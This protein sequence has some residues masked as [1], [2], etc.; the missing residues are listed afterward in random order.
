[1]TFGCEQPTPH[2]FHIV[3]LRIRN[4]YFMRRQIV[5]GKTM[6]RGSIVA[7]L[8]MWGGSLIPFVSVATQVHGQTLTVMSSFNGT[9]L[10]NSWGGL[11]LSGS[12]LYG[13]TINGGPNN[14]GT[15]FSLPLTGGTSTVLASF[16]GANGQGPC[17]TLT[18][19]GST[20]YGTTPKGGANNDGTVFS[21]PVTGG[22][23]T[24]LTSFNNTNG[25]S[26]AG[27]LA[28]SGSTLYGTTSSG[29]GYGEGEVFSLPVT[30]GNP[31][32]LVSCNGATSNPS[33]GVLLSGNTLYGTAQTGAGDFGTVFSLPAGGGNP[34][35][36][37][38]F[39]G[40]NGQWPES[41]LV[42]SGTTLYG[43]AFEGGASWNGGIGG[44]G[45]VFSV[46]VTGGTPTVLA[47]FNGVNG[48]GPASLAISGRILYGTTDYGGAYG[49]GEAFSIP[50]TGGTLTVLHSFNFTDGAYPQNGVT[51]VGSTLYG[52]TNGGGAFNAGEVFSL[53]LPNFAQYSWNADASG[54]WSVAS[55]WD[56]ATRYGVNDQVTFGG[57]ITAPRTITVDSAV[58]A[59]GLTFNSTPAY[60]IAGSRSI[61]LQA[62][63]GDAILNVV[64]G[65]HAISAPL[66][67]ASN[68]DVTFINP[69]N[70]L[71]ISGSISGSETAL[72]L[73]GAGTLVLGAANT[74]SG[75]TDVS[76]GTLQL[77]HPL[78]VQNSTV[79]VSAS[80]ALAFAAGVTNPTLGGLA[81]AGNISLA[82]AASQPVTLGAGGNG[83]NTV[84][85][86]A[87]SGAG[88]L[89]KQ[90]GGTLTLAGTSTYAGPTLIAGGIL[91]LQPPANRSIGVQFY[92]SGGAAALTGTGGV[93]PMTNWNC[94]P[95]YSYSSSPLVDNLG[96][97]SG[98]VFSLNGASGI[99]S[100]LSSNPLLNDY[101]WGYS[102]MTITT[103]NI[104]Y[105]RY[106]IYVYTNDLQGGRQKMATV[107]GVTYYYNSEGVGPSAF[108]AI[109]ST[110]PSNS[111]MGNYIEVDGLT[112]SS[113]TVL[114]S[115]LCGLEIVDTVP[116]SGVNILPSTTALSIASGG[117]LDLSGGSQQ[118]TSLSDKA[119][120]SGGSIVNSETTAAVLTVSP[121]G[122]STTFSGM[123]RG[124]GTSGTIR[125]VKSG[126]GTQVLAG[127]N[128]YTGG[129]AVNA[130]TL[131]AA[132]TASLPGYASTGKI[133][134]ASGGVLAVSAGGSGWT[135]ANIGTLLSS[136]GS[137]FAGGS[138]LGIDTTA[139][140]FSFASNIAGSMGLVKLVRIH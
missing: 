29:G 42:L 57:A 62:S 99:G 97:P 27:S 67:L 103:S 95:G 19:S 46:P 102:S 20:L 74:Y 100:T 127:S 32:V 10:A 120:G 43:T 70:S 83:Q 30:G 25:N 28:L 4:V 75:S 118:V 56:N 126:S 82:T 119:P 55:N 107:N 44:M 2:Y 72:S 137:G 86:G 96:N 36:L 34:T 87:L 45:D 108:A 85:S 17:C 125:F 138:A 9:A 12:T 16:N 51:P 68:T 91:Q 139:G 38:S 117:T 64:N 49:N 1:M 110:N 115:N 78:A 69:G 47:S 7:A 71:T 132:S 113:Q 122:G 135:A 94:E 111:P 92:G 31:T 33:G 130:G 24:V 89:T 65:S 40:S 88:G 114:S 77:A 98:A 93:V 5:F 131:Q 79:S 13:T 11:I 41:A 66:V 101:A 136:N 48:Q 81:G 128:T 3:W 109:T 6:V 54:A 76:T 18:L 14:D 90:G 73:Y 26:P 37:T 121:T 21:V 112:G 22:S 61:T 35:I 59:G 106:S 129:T 15:V 140:N 80:G 8:W 124:G 52:A 104:P 23:L 105:A 58:T 53:Q 50:A 116:G 123:I 63:L 39:S 60:T 133:T 134:M 84:Y